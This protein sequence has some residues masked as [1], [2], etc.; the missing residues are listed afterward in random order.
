[1]PSPVLNPLSCWALN[2]VHG[3]CSRLYLCSD[4]YS[5]LNII[6]LSKLRLNQQI[7]NKLWASREPP[8]S[9]SAPLWWDG[10]WSQPGL[11]KGVHKEWEADPDVGLE[12]Y[13]THYHYTCVQPAL[14][15]DRNCT[16]TFKNHPTNRCTRAECRDL[17]PCWWW[18]M[19]IILDKGGSGA[20]SKP[21][22]V[23]EWGGWGGGT[24]NL[25]R[26]GEVCRQWFKMTPD[27]YMC[28]SSSKR[29]IGLLPFYK[30]CHFVLMPI[31]CHV[32][33][34]VAGEMCVCSLYNTAGASSWE[35]QDQIRVCGRW[36]KFLSVIC[37][38]AL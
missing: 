30:S 8:V 11:C 13:C 24:L 10:W 15:G 16:F 27:S 9:V 4:K 14:E 33:E 29:P 22:V 32:F 37:R 26:I 7:K 21:D 23:A 18:F 25:P 36:V 3:H 28:I 5:Q 1:M 31:Q 17:I 6:D 20:R 19:C 12:M 38:C 35:Y 34:L 2:I